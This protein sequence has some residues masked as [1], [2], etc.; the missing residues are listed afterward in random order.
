M[1]KSMLFHW[2]RAGTA[3]DVIHFHLIVDEGARAFFGAELVSKGLPRSCATFYD[4]ESVCGEGTEDFLAAFGF[5]LSAHYSGKAGYCRLFLPPVIQ[6]DKFIAIESD[7]IFFD[8]VALL[9]ED[10]DRMPEGTLVAAPEMYQPWFDGRPGGAGGGAGSGAG[11]EV[12]MATNAFGPA[13]EGLD[14]SYHGYGYIGGIMAFR[15]K[16]MVGA[17]WEDLWRSEL[18]AFI[19]ASEEGWAPRLNDQDVF[20]AVFSRRPEL[21]ANFD[22]SWNL[23]YHAFMNSARLC[24]GRGL[25]C[26]ES[27]VTDMFVCPK[28][29]KVVHF[30]AGSYKQSSAQY[31]SQFWDSFRKLDMGLIREGLDFE[32]RLRK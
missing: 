4:F 29:P 23:Q 2:G 30:M 12:K 5:S 31:Y 11:G 15:S 20:N 17:G 25:N 6:A 18:E 28:R 21:A 14:A 16:A 3:R 27:I 8:D 22:C 1:I 7:Q 19:R 26:E 9:F 13:G 10:F 32:T 24:G